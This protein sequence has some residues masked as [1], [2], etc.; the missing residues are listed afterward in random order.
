MSN[1]PVISV[2]IHQMLSLRVMFFRKR[3]ICQNNASLHTVSIFLRT[4]DCNIVPY[5]I[6]PYKLITY[7]FIFQ[8]FRY[9]NYI[10]KMSVVQFLESVR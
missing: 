1:I 2:S 5:H 6:I 9:C 7:V 3:L 4:D 8:N 10:P